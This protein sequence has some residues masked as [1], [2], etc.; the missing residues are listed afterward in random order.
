MISEFEKTCLSDLANI[1]DISIRYHEN[2]K[3]EDLFDAREIPASLLSFI[4]RHHK[5]F[6]IG[7]YTNR[8][9]ICRVSLQLGLESMFIPTRQDSYLEIGPYLPSFLTIDEI[10]ARLTEYGLKPEPALIRFFTNDCPVLSEGKIESLQRMLYSILN[11]GMSCTVVRIS[12]SRDM[13]VTTEAISI[14]RIEENKKIIFRY[15]SFVPFLE[16]LSK[17]DFQKCLELIM[18]SPQYKIG[19]HFSEDRFK[20]EKVKAIYY[21]S[22][23]SFICTGSGVSPISAD[24]LFCRFI[25]KITSLKTTEQVTQANFDMLRSF[26]DLVQQESQQHSQTVKRILYYLSLHVNVPLNMDDLS[27]AIQLPRSK[28][29]SIFKKECGLSILKYHQE[30]RL[31]RAAELLL[32][33]AL[34]ISQVALQAG[35]PDQNY[36][37]RV[38]KKA[39][40]YTPRYY[41]DM[42]LHTAVQHNFKA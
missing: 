12:D 42:F 5:H 34:S 20:N 10:A 33:R 41:R 3:S 30:M 27:E 15:E 36:F 8:G 25:R 2:N 4:R 6:S 13:P 22:I 14:E 7:S 18:A 40:G 26:C 31:N 24:Q 37:S 9:Y 21:A 39:Y 19:D 11:P 23:F 1:S 29:E 38:F 35:F 28:C 17:G 16:A 32:D